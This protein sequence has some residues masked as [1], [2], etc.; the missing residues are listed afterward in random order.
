[1]GFRAVEVWPLGGILTAV[2]P[3]LFSP[4]LPAVLSSILVF[5]LFTRRMSRSWLIGVV[6]WRVCYEFVVMDGFDISKYFDSHFSR[7][8]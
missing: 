8:G 2:Y 3:F 6:G 5:P 7:S 4:H 1:M